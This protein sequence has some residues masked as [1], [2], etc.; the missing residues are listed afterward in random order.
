M[1]IHPIDPVYDAGSRVLLLGSFPSPKSRE[2]G[3]P[4]GHPQNRFWPVLAALWGEPVPEGADER[5]AF[6]LRHHIALWD[7]LHACEIAGASDASIQ[8]PIPN[9]IRPILAAAPI[10]NIYTTGS[11]SHKLYKK[12]I[13]PVCG[14]PAIPLPSTSPANARMRLPALIAAYR[15][16]L[17]ALDAPIDR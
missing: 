12:Y 16:I 14:R 11:T 9:D 1:L 2:M 7:V 6:A 13:E 17:E 4:Y 3:F 5:R 10:H 8:H 15:V